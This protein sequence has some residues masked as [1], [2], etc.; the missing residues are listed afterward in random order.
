[1]HIS[2]HSLFIADRAKQIKTKATVNE[3]PTDK[4]IRELRDQNEKLRAQMAG[5]KVDMAEI[6]Q[7]AKRDNLTKEEIEQLKKEWMAEIEAEA[8]ANDKELEEMKLSYEEKLKAAQAASNAGNWVF[9]FVI[10]ATSI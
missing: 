7:I 3:D 8:K 5:G 4:L 2:G 10:L 9:L 1:M 6:N